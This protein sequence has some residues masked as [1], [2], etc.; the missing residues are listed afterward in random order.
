MT[1]ALLLLLGLGGLLLIWRFA[2]WR[3]RPLPG[4]TRTTPLL[5]GHRGVRGPA[6]ENTAAAFELAF[7]AGL[8][9]VETDVQRTAD[10]VLVLFHDFTLDGQPLWT[11]R[12]SD[13][14]ARVPDLA[15]LDDLFAV[16]RRYPGTL[17]NLELK[18]DGLR[19]GG[20]ERAAVQA[21]RASGLQDRILVSSFNPAT[22]LKVRLLAPEVRIGLL[23]APDLPAWLRSGALAGWLHADA[24]HPHESLVTP[25]LLARARAESVKVNTWTVN[26]PMRITSLHALGADAIIGDDPR[27]LLASRPV[28]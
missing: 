24:L 26:D 22:L 11:Y 21:I 8:D 28:P 9:G 4:V 13:L 1:T 20:L 5:I 27:V 6:P 14:R 12:L 25:E 3:P 16:A 18:A 17:L 15:T 2:L 7:G 10:G 19:T 23:Y